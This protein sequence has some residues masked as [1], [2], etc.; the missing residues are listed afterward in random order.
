MRTKLELKLLNRDDVLILSN[1]VEKCKI[2]T[3][4]FKTNQKSKDYSFLQ[5]FML[6][7]GFVSHHHLNSY[8]HEIISGFAKK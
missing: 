2:F 6:S 8:E 7:A 4:N 1:L 3:A 5:K